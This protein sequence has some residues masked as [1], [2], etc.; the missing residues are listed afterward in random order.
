MDV[1]FFFD[2]YQFHFTLQTEWG[3]D[4]PI[5][6]Y[7]GGGCNSNEFNNAHIMLNRMCA[8]CKDQSEDDRK[9]IDKIDGLKF[10]RVSPESFKQL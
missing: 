7:C 4:L 2:C 10:R 1:S 5:P 3:A 9:I 8:P 6:L